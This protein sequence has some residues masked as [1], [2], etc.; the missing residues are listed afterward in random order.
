MYEEELGPNGK[1][2]SKRDSPAD[3]GHRDHFRKGI[4]SNSQE[5]L[6]TARAAGADGGQ[7]AA[8]SSAVLALGRR[9]SAL[10]KHTDTFLK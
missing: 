5:L 7:E 8:G 6:D 4:H 9:A 10:S 1:V 2:T 3:V